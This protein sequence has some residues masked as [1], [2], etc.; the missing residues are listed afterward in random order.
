VLAAG[1]TVLGKSASALAGTLR[2]HG[3]LHERDVPI[4][5]TEPLRGG[6]LDGRELRNRDLYDLLLNK[7]A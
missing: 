4:I 5:V 1:E 3:A 2:S 7:V 6:A